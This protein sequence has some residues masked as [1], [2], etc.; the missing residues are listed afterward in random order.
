MLRESLDGRMR[1][2]VRGFHY[3]G[4][5]HVFRIE[6]FS[7]AVFG[8]SLTL[9]VVSLEVPKSFAD[10]LTTIGAFPAFAASFALIAQIW[11][12]QYRFFR[13]YGIE[14]GPTVALNV[15]LLFVVVF[16]IYP[17]KFLFRL[18]LSGGAPQGWSD[19]D[20]LPLYSI[21]DSGYAAI[22]MIFILLY[23]HA[24]RKRRALA[25]NAL[26]LFD[27]KMQIFRSAFQIVVAAASLGSA[28][29]F[30]ARGEC[31]IA[32]FAGGYAYPVLLAPGLTIIGY[33]GGAKR[34]RL[35]TT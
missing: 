16:F 22:F 19:A 8:F 26:E 12:L 24:Y 21:Y 27:T 28:A 17:L 3:R 33:V 25:L 34:R 10:L 32:A 4:H 20:V 6:S 7:D 14:D 15:M 23:V 1:E 29:F 5:H 11:Y 31:G 2:T 18:A 13:R 9:L 35:Q 30:C